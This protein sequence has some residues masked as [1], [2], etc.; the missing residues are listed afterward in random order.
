MWNLVKCFLKVCV[1][2]RKHGDATLDDENAA[3]HVTSILV[4]ALCNQLEAFSSDVGDD[5]S[6]YLFFYHIT[7]LL[8]LVR[9]QSMTLYI[10]CCGNLTRMFVYYTVECGLLK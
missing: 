1:Y 6:H 8:L 7:V 2:Q 9:V 10:M 4:T 5:Q 3:Q